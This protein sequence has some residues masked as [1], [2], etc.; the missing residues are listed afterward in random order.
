MAPTPTKKKQSALLR[1]A[2]RNVAS[3]PSG[4][5]NR[6]GPGGISMRPAGGARRHLAAPST[7]LGA[8]ANRLV[9]PG[10]RLPSISYP[11][12]ADATAAL[13]AARSPGASSGGG[14][15]SWFQNLGKD[16]MSV[17][18][19]VPG[20]LSL[21]GR[22]AAVP[23]VGTYGYTAGLVLPGGSGAREFTSDVGKDWATGAIATGQDLKTRWG[24]LL[25][26]DMDEF[27]RQI[28]QHPGF[29]ALDAATL[30]SAGVGA[31]AKGAQAGARVGQGLTRARFTRIAEGKTAF[32]SNAPPPGWASSILK[33]TTEPPKGGVIRRDAKG[34]PLAQQPRGKAP[35]ADNIRLLNPSTRQLVPEPPKRSGA[36]PAGRT[37]MITPGM[38]EKLLTSPKLR[39]L[40]ESRKVG[41]RART[42]T[43]STP[44]QSVTLKDGRTLKLELPT[45]EVALR[46]YSPNVATR[47]MQK[48]WDNRVMG[49]LERTP[50]PAA[51]SARARTATCPRRP[52]TSARSAARR[53]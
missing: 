28:K 23:A 36:Q 44:L 12:Q 30:A 35:S 26:G 20:T 2:L 17:I 39:S 50:T 38:L 22:T 15:G 42:R 43:L 53:A 48:A 4:T 33:A 40:G 8:Y 41:R 5:N 10:A 3:S 29:F 21:V 1:Y 25:R 19:G 34:R 46:R 16:M 32:P 31:A 7:G 47:Q 18:H 52:A 49:T 13:F 9:R 6:K 24:P 11:G 45:K 37:Q 14:G 27:A 51:P